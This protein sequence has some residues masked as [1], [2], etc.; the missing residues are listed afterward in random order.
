MIKDV[1]YL[2]QYMRISSIQIDL[3]LSQERLCVQ[4]I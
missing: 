2:V 4:V 3:K 1:Y